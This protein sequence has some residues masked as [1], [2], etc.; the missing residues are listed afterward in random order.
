MIIIGFV[1]GDERLKQGKHFGKDYFDNLLDTS[2]RTSVLSENHR[3][4]KEIST[5]NRLS[6]AFLDLA[7]LRAKRQIISTMAD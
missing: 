3:S 5:F 6:T 7:E 1:L 4:D 2:F